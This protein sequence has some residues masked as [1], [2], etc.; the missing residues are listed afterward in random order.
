MEITTKTIVADIVKHNYKTAQIFENKRIN[1]C[2][3]GNKSLDQA[4]MEAGVSVEETMQQIYSLENKEQLQSKYFE[5]LSIDQLCDYIEERFHRSVDNQMPFIFAKIIK[6]CNSHG[7]KHNEVFAIRSLFQGL[8]EQLSSHMKK[9]ELMLFPY[10]K[11]MKKAETVGGEPPKSVFGD[12]KALLSHME[13]ELHSG[14]QMLDKISDLS[15]S[16]TKPKGGC[17]TFEVTYRSLEDFDN[18][19]KEYMFIENNILYPKVLSL[20]QRMSQN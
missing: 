9:G 13:K 4:C 3:G 6:L 2:C 1:F 17:N 10:I 5:H 12:L 16:Y 15:N 11:N 18:E 14:N 8:A 7:H 19:L 20:K